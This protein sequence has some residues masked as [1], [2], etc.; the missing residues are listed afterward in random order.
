MTIKIKLWTAVSTWKGTIL[1]F[2]TVDDAKIFDN[3]EPF[4]NCKNPPDRIAEKQIMELA[5]T[6]EAIRQLGNCRYLMKLNTSWENLISDK[7]YQEITGLDNCSAEEIT[8]EA[9]LFCKHGGF[10]YPIDPGYVATPVDDMQLTLEE[11]AFAEKY[12]LSEEQCKALFDI[13]EYFREHPELAVGTTIFAF[14][15]LGENG[16]DN[17]WNGINKYHPNGQFGA[18]LIVTKDG[19]LSYA[20]TRASTLPD[21]MEKSATVKE[22]IYSVKSIPHPLNGGYAAVRLTQF[23]TD[24]SVLSAYNSK[25]GN[26]TAEGINLHMAGRI[27]SDDPEHPYSEGCITVTV[28]KYRDFGVATG[29]I[30]DREEN[31]TA[32]SDGV[33]RNAKGPLNYG[34]NA[35]KDFNGSMVI[36]RK[37]YE[38][39]AGYLK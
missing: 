18:I 15:G 29:F 20:E 4:G 31:R 28:D 26:G 25:H 33:Y 38:D 32:G 22:G 39:A 3:I 8:M 23:G 36:D 1:L 27:H 14:E 13:R 21:N 6:S 9:V 11:K 7:G 17:N 30:R 34:D 5:G 35:E 37:Y 24:N 2:A 12:G 19:L 16:T 10:I